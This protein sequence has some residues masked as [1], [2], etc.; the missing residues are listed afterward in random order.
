MANRTKW[1]QYRRVKRTKAEY[2]AALQTVIGLAALGVGEHQEAAAA[3]AIL[4]VGAR[5][6][7]TLRK[8]RRQR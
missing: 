1:A 7:S 3:Q 5:P 2:R 6:C 8:R 4:A